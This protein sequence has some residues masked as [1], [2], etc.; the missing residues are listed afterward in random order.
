M[1]SMGIGGN[2]KEGNEIER[3]EDNPSYDLNKYMKIWKTY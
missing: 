1:C 2:I 3:N